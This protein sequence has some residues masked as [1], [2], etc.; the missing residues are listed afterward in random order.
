[1]ADALGDEVD[2]ILDCGPTPGQGVST[3]L[4]VVS[5]PYAILRQGVLDRE[6]LKEILGDRLAG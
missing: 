5:Q 4:S 2:L 1:V 3:I 6:T